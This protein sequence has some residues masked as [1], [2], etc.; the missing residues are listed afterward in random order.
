MR[1][2]SAANRLENG[3]AYSPNNRPESRGESLGIANTVL[4]TT[5]NVP[6]DAEASH[7]LP[8]ILCYTA[9]GTRG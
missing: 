8:T 9:I 1:A 6:L 7:S 4:A 3:L 2:V 5:R